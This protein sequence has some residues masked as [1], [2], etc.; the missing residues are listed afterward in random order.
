MQ[1]QLRQMQA[2]L[3]QNG[4]MGQ[5]N[6][7]MQPNGHGQTNG[8]VQMPGHPG[9]SSLFTDAAARKKELEQGVGRCR[10][11]DG[12]QHIHGSALN[13]KR[14]PEMDMFM[15]D[16]DIQDLSKVPGLVINGLECFV[17]SGQSAQP[18]VTHA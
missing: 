2:Q 8:G 10:K 7:V 16:L 18:Y 9:G 3:G 6:G 17:V 4:A 12:S 11:G 1:E 14:Q 5:R 15:N 13:G